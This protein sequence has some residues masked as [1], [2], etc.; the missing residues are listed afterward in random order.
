MFFNLFWTFYNFCPC[1]SDFKCVGLIK[2]QNYGIMKLIYEQSVILFASLWGWAPNLRGFLTSAK[3]AKY[4]LYSSSLIQRFW[5][6]DLIFSSKIVT[7]IVLSL[8]KEYKLCELQEKS[9][10]IEEK[11]IN[12]RIKWKLICETSWIINAT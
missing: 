6:K 8:T 4:L 3:L 9:I 2:Y 7:Q 1:P 12:K 11:K 10:N 5:D